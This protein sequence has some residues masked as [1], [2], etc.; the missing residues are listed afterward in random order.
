[1]DAVQRIGTVLQPCGA[2]P[3]WLTWVY[4]LVAVAEQDTADTVVLSAAV[5][6][7]IDCVGGDVAEVLGEDLRLGTYSMCS[8]PSSM[9]GLASPRA[10]VLA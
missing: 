2:G 8:Q 1:M 9:I 5:E 10:P 7:A 6:D 3:A 4:A